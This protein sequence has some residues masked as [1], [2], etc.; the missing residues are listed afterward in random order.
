MYNFEEDAVNED[1]NILHNVHQQGGLEVDA[2]RKIVQPLRD[3]KWIG[4]GANAFYQADDD[5]LKTYEA[6]NDDILRFEATVRQ[7]MDATQDTV[8]QI[9]A[10]I[11]R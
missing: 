2:I 5:F 9:D 10:V 11:A 8:S 6:L 1:L 4:L 7:A 3:G